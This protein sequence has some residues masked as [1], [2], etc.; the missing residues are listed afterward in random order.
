[1]HILILAWCIRNPGLDCHP[2]S[3]YILT[4]IGSFALHIVSIDKF[5]FY[6]LSPMGHSMI[7]EK[8]DSRPLP[9]AGPRP[10]ERK[11][12]RRVAMSPNYWYKLCSHSGYSSGFNPEKGKTA[13]FEAGER[14]TQELRLTTIWAYYLL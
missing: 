14:D 12:Q 7:S 11:R 13:P 4:D 9:E 3:I 1:M 10:G 2:R 5:I 8:K 6:F